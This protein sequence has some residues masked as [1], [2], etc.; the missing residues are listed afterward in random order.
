MIER[1]ILS[2]LEEMRKH[3]SVIMLTGARQVGKTTLL[4]ELRNKHSHI[5]YV[6][7]DYP[8]IRDLARKDP[9]GFLE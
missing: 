1:A 9:Q 8:N 3:F 5:N 7:L 2:K 4:Q 6:T